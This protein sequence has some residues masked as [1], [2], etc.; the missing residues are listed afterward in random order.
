[1][2]I[3]H[4]LALLAGFTAAGLIAVAG[5]GLYGVVSIQSD[6]R[7]L[8][9]HATP[10]QSKTYEV[11]ERTERVVGN[12]LK[13]S[14]ATE[15]DD[16]DKT[17]AAIE[18]EMRELDRLRAEMQ[19]LDASAAGDFTEFRNVQSQIAKT[20]SQRLADEASYK[21]DTENARSTLARAEEAVAASR[22]AVGGVETDAAKSADR[23]QDANRALSTTMKL[24]LTAQAR[25]KELAIIVNETDGVTNRFRLGP[26]KER[27]KA[28]VDSVLRLDS[29]HDG[30]DALK[31]VKV[32]AVAVQ[33]ALMRDGN[34]L[35]ALRA[36]VLTQKAD[37]DAYAKQRRAIVG[38]LD[39]QT[40]KL[41]AII[42]GLEVQIVKQRRSLEEALRF[43]NEPGG[44]VVLN[45]AIFFDMKEM[46]SAIRLLMLASTPDEA[47][48]SL[49]TLQQLQRKMTGNLGNLR[50]ALLK[51]GKAAIARNAED[52]AAAMKS[53][54]A[55][56]ARVGLT[57]QSVLASEIAA[58]EAIA[59][60]KAI[61]AQ[62]SSRGQQQVKSINERQQE[63]TATVDR[64]VDFAL[65]LIVAIAGAI[66]AGA[67]LLS[68]STIR[69]VTRRLGEAVDVAEAVSRGQ[70]D[71][72]PETKGND[73]TAR[74]LAA[75]GAMVQ[76]LIDI[77]ARIKNASDSID[78][79]SNEI[80]QGNRHLSSR[81]EQQASSL[82][83]TAASMEQLAGTVRQNSEA[84]GNANK[85]AV[86]ALDVASQGGVT[87]V[88]MGSTMKEIET[89]SRRIS[90]IVGVMD[91]I[92]F[93]TNILALNAAVEAARAGE[94]GRGFAVVASEVRALA[95]KSSQAA[96]EIRRLIA[97]NV[98]RV[99]AGAKLA[100]KAGTTM[101]DIVGQMNEVTDLVAAISTASRDQF[102]SVR[103]VSA[104][105][106]QLDEMTQQN[107]ALAEQS[108]AAATSLVDQSRGLAETVSAFRVAAA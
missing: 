38:Q 9:S 13:L 91:G 8:T 107:A 76:T 59:R 39:D 87:I 61:A 54:G 49:A 104:A 32:A 4:R 10:L 66:I 95:L 80:S 72:L 6:L 96:E 57:K 51:I 68:L 64:R 75:L 22:A 12:L 74:L 20:V 43:R 100:H 24:A 33:D 85:L 2:K 93:Q 44:I 40:N 86:Q 21:T 48:K 16:A 92:S 77:V 56:I 28:H 88:E 46:T 106:T 41:G 37:A 99:E 36:D 108:T 97:D 65:I 102:D 103:Q 11:Q 63:V 14:V 71:Q 5:V 27:V 84:A 105:V 50:A 15:K 3:A 42:D 83:Q 25:L 18:T 81:T 79:C 62:Q 17:V 78:T 69:T 82:Q 52:A 58:R 31:D 67:V 90:E 94:A 47:T 26:L 19:K 70:L 98:G 30:V 34:G 101:F 53:V 1:M 29:V 7:G 89:S 55:S 60:L 45:D 73:E 35:M 23:A